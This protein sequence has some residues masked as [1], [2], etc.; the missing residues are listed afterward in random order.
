MSERDDTGSEQLWY[1][2]S[3]AEQPYNCDD[4]G[5]VRIETRRPIHWMLDREISDIMIGEDVSALKRY[6]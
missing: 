3:H 6:H 4:L 1:G 5:A 2:Y